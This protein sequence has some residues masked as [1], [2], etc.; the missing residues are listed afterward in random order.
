MLFPLVAQTPLL[1]RPF[2]SGRF[3]EPAKAEPQLPQMNKDRTFAA[4][5]I[6]LLELCDRRLLEESIWWQTLG[7]VDENQKS[8]ALYRLVVAGKW[9]EDVEAE[10]GF[11]MASAIK[12]CLNESPRSLDG[13]QW[14][15]DLADRVVLPIQNCCQYLSKGV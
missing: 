7:F 11:G 13:E 15:R 3:K 1:S 5:G 12:W 14:R 8:Q 6:M 2:I 9:S 10:E 4:L